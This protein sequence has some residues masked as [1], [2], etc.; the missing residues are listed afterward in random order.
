MFRLER[1]GTGGVGVLIAS[2]APDPR[3]AVGVDH[4]TGSAGSQEPHSAYSDSRATISVALKVKPQPLRLGSSLRC[5]QWSDAPQIGLEISPRTRWRLSDDD[6]TVFRTNSVRLRRYATRHTTLTTSSIWHHALIDS[7]AARSYLHPL[8][9]YTRVGKR[10][11][12]KT[13]WM[14]TCVCVC[15]CV[16][17]KGST[18]P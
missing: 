5:G 9:A 3:P 16:C 4:G 15:V 14:L 18:H 13:A 12:D 10:T 8:E 2:P 11:S 1:V 17:V 6:D 7:N